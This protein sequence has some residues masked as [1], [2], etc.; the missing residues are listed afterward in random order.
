MLAPARRDGSAKAAAR[1]RPR[2]AYRRSAAGP[3]RGQAQPVLAI[4][5]EAGQN[6]A[7]ATAAGTAKGVGLAPQVVLVGEAVERAARWVAGE[8]AARHH[9]DGNVAG[10]QHAGTES[11]DPRR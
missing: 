8:G 6:V 1:S 4:G 11:L 7:A 9:P 2:A 10:A 5:L 3:I